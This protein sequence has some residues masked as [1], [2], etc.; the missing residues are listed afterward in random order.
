VFITKK[1]LPRRTFLRGMG[2]TLG[3]PL[4]ESMV[5]ALTATAQTAA[6]PQ[7]RF[8]AVYVPHGVIMEQW[9]PATAGADFQ[10]MPI[11]KPLE[12]FRDSLVVVSNLG[13]PER[14]D[15][16][17]H[18]GA[19]ASWLTGVT[20]KRT[21]GA[22]FRLAESIDQVIVRQ[23][24]GDTT[25][26]SLEVATEDFTM[27]LGSCAPGYS[28]AYAN[29]L[30]WQSPTT[31][32]PMEINPRN[33][34]RRMFGE[35]DN[36]EQR[37]SRRRVDRS[38]LDFLA[39][40][41]TRLEQGIGRADRIRLDE[42]LAHVREVERRIQQ[43]ER[44]ADTTLTVPTAPAGVPESYGEH[45]GVT[46]ELL[47]LAYEADLTRVFTFMMA[48]ELSQLTYPHIDANLPHHV[49]SHHGGKPEMV[50][51]HARIN[52]YHLELFAKFL[53][54]LRTTR[55]GDG[56]LLEHSM[57]LYG[58]GMGNGNLHAAYPLPL[59]LVGGKSLVKGNR[60]VVPAENS[61]N[62]NLMVSMA[63]K[64][65]VEMERFGVSTG[66]VDI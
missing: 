56:S 52:I 53:E 24:G 9:V 26:P 12:P 1:S 47:A 22:D 20:P 8:A 62:A 3:L 11:M 32:L 36:A 45:V 18:A 7:K 23:I 21:D 17:N 28:C 5:P 37:L 57:I 50:S 59:V 34:F 41:L 39:E 2:V 29:T 14:G 55:D 30:S 16:T 10:F 15:N 25:F 43:A 64:F 44:Q 31:P 38:I 63:Q 33:L 35:G 40:D 54:R 61:P 42:Y 13:R 48:R 49:L 27:Q 4:L 60:H 19:P 66:S 46:F 58:S 51:A 6:N 65:G